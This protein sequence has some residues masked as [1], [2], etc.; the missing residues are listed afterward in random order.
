M[1]RRAIFYYLSNRY[2][3]H[4]VHYIYIYIYLYTHDQPRGLVVRVS[5]YRVRFPVLPW[6]FSLKGRI[7]AVSMVWVG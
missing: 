4:V 7:P 5:D 1:A 3:R 2:V 6:E